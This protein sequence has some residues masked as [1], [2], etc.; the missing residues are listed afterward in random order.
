MEGPLKVPDRLLVAA[1]AWA[2][3]SAAPRTGVAQEAAP[4][5]PAAAERLPAGVRPGDVVRVWI[6]RE[7]DLTGEFAVDARGRV[8]LPLL[9]ERTVAG[10]SSEQLADLLRNDFRR[11]LTNPSIQVT[12]LRRLTVSGQVA[13]PGL[14]PVDATVTVGDAIALAGGLTPTANASRIRLIRDGRVLTTAVE[15]SLVLE[16]SEVQSGDAIHVPERSWLSRNAP[17][18]ALGML[19]AVAA[20]LTVGLLLR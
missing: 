16:R 20:S 3:A 15:P 8:V 19:S 10:A 2:M 5:S 14:Y 4:A 13:R 7:A 11:Y 9:G 6:W 18:V 17:G 12:V 1:A